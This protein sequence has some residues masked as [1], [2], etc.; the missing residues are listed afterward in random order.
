MEAKITFDKKLKVYPTRNDS[1]R[2]IIE[3]IFIEDI[4]GLKNEG[5]SILLVRKNT[6]NGFSSLDC[7]E[8]CLVDSTKQK[9]E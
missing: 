7:L 4:L 2:T 9:L 5:D 3:T 8:S 6:I 1:D